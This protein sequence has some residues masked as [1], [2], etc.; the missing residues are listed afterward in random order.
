M[1]TV[2]SVARGNQWNRYISLLMKQEFIKHLLCPCPEQGTWSVEV[3]R[4]DSCSWRAASLVGETSAE[5]MIDVQTASLGGTE[6][7]GRGSTEEETYPWGEGQRR[8]LS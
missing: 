1:V 7:R 3:S 5:T 2:V 8:L 6:R 4:Q